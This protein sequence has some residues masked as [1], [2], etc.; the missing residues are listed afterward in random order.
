[1]VVVLEDVSLSGPLVHLLCDDTKS[2]SDFALHHQ[3]GKGADHLAI[4]LFLSTVGPPGELVLDGAAFDYQS[5]YITFGPYFQP[6]FQMADVIFDL[7][8]WM[9]FLEH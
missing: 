4:R 9:W 5:I 6:T 8:L 2:S 3:F 7:G 1:M